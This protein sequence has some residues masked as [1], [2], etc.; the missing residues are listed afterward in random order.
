MA[1]PTVL[2][3]DT[4][5]APP[6]PPPVDAAVRDR[7]PLVVSRAGWLIREALLASLLLGVTIGLQVAAGAYQSERNSY[8]DEAAH[9]MNALVLRDYIREG[10]SQNPLRFAEDYYR[11]YPKIAPGMWP[12]LFS[13]AVAVLMLPGWPPQSA[14]FAFLALLS[15]WAAWR[16]H[17]FIRSFSTSAI[18]AILTGV[19]CVIPAIV[20]L[21]T[22][23]MVDLLILALALE[24]THWLA[25]FFSTGR[26]RDALLFGLFS[27]LCCLSK[28]NG[29]A[30]AFLPLALAV[31]TRRYDRLATPDL[32]IAAAM[33]AVVAG[34]P[35][36]VAYRLDAAIGDFGTVHGHDVIERLV[37]YSTSV[38]RQFGPA[39]VALALIGFVAAV[40]P[41][42]RAALSEASANKAALAALV[43]AGLLFHLVNPH[44]IAAPR[45]MVMVY[46][47]LLALVP[48]GI[49]ALASVVRSESARQPVRI[50]IL[51]AAVAGFVAAAPA[52][53][54][55]QS[56]G[57]RATVDFIEQSRGLPNSKTLVVSDEYGE[58]AMVSEVA[59][60]HPTPRATIIRG[61]KFIATEDWAGNRF[62]LHYESPA[63]LLADIE[64]L[65]IDF[66]VMD[67]SPNAAGLRFG[68]LV[69]SMIDTSPSR[70]EPVFETQAARRLVTYRLKYRTPGVSKVLEVPVLYSLGRVLK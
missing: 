33:V 42:R 32:Y 54:L 7:G 48:L 26:T 1:T 69:R 21:T 59:R 36:A 15:A 46:P 52:V 64:A 55:R 28:G 63:A 56:L 62:R 6:T 8:S 53:P 29:L 45:Y 66:V 24:A 5:Y 38:W 22:A 67:Y 19:F 47:A 3:A 4:L 12:P 51:L 41:G 11:H 65:H 18:A 43:V 17:R 13:T 70:L 2:P 9:F 34:P 37:L 40:V 16:L 68:S 57:A 49:D 14:T 27:T 39:L 23:A 25:R 60:R 30:L 50:A 31:I 58:G 20:E 10:L 61:S 44:L 35:M